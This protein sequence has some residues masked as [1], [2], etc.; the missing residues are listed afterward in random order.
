MRGTGYLFLEHEKDFFIGGLIFLIQSLD[1]PINL[2]LGR[3]DP[4]RN[5][6]RLDLIHQQ[7]PIRQPK[8]SE[9][10]ELYLVRLQESQQKPPR[11]RS[12]TFVHPL[13]RL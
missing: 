6:P 4:P 12:S 2:L 11:H 5:L 7:S 9:T 13:S 8:P 1:N 10:Y 3:F